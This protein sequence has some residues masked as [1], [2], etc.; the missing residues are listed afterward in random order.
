[1]SA[2]ENYC[3]LIISTVHP[4]STHLWRN[5][6]IVA[7]G[8]FFSDVGLIHVV[9]IVKTL[10][11]SPYH[12]AGNPT[13]RGSFNYLN[14]S[15]FEYLLPCWERVWIYDQACRKQEQCRQYFWFFHLVRIPLVWAITEHVCSQFRKLWDQSRLRGTNTSYSGV[16]LRQY[17]VHRTERNPRS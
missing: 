1:M 16:C 13:K 12:V 15:R 11:G 2:Q 7:T 6:P 8:M 4:H 5:F 9:N 14:P 17:G 3:T 10:D